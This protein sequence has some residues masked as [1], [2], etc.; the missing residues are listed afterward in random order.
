MAEQSRSIPS[1]ELRTS[2]TKL[3]LLTPSAEQPE[4]TLNSAGSSV[5]LSRSCVS[6]LSLGDMAQVTLRVQMALSLS[7]GTVPCLPALTAS[8]QVLCVFF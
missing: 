5:A 3:A 6:V 2:R 7:R 1:Q 8:Q 4:H